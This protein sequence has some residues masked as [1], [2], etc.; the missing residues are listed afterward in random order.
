MGIIINNSS[1]LNLTLGV[2]GAGKSTFVNNMVSKF[3]LQVLC[4]DDVR[5]ALGDVY[6]E[7]TEPV[8][9]MISNVMGRAFMERSLPIIVDSTCTS[10]KIVEM[11][12][13][14]AKE[15]D[16]KIHAYFL[17]TPFDVCCDRR[18]DK[19]DMKILTRQ[20]DQLHELMFWLKEN[21]PFDKFET[22][23]F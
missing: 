15:Y 5:L 13:R 16:Y 4:L 11:W 21:E 17:D 8:V 12:C 19:I 3:P 20:R 22:V 7:R 6:D 23:K 18:A 9:R 10:I 14:L 2:A 1:I